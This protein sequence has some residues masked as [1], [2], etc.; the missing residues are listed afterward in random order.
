MKLGERLAKIRNEK[1][2]KQKDIAKALDVSQQ[3]IS[4]IERGET[5]PDI[6][7]LKRLADLYEMSLDELVGRHFNVDNEN[8]IEK[9]IM[10]IISTLDDEGK[11]LSYDLLDKVAQH[12]GKQ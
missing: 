10:N 3:V 5:S 6:D 9:R 8:S 7:L 12:Q 11:E 1:E 4:N 2:Y